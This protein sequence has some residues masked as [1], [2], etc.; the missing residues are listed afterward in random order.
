MFWGWET[1]LLPVGVLGAVLV[2][3]PRVVRWRWDFSAQ[4]M[5]RFW[6][7]CGV[8]FMA[9]V[10][11][12]FVATDI[13]KAAAEYFIWLPII[14]FPFLAATIYSARDNVRFSTYLWLLRPKK[15]TPATG[16]GIGH[17]V[18]YWYFL[19]CFISSSM[20][21]VRDEWFY[22]GVTVLGGWLLWSVRN[23][24]EP[25]WVW[26]AIL[27]VVAAIGLQGHL[28]LTRLKTLITVMA[29]QMLLE[30]SVTDLDIAQSRTAIGE[31]GEIKLSGRI[32]LRL[33][34]DAPYPPPELL[35]QASYNIYS[36]YDRHAVWSVQKTRFSNMFP[37][38]DST[39]WSLVSNDTAKSSVTLSMP[40]TAVACVMPVPAGMASLEGLVAGLVQTNDF[41]SIRVRDTPPLIRCKLKY[42]TT[43]TQEAPVREADLA[44]PREESVALAKI[45]AEL[46]LASQPAPEVLRR[47]GAFF[48]DN[49]HYS[50][51]LK[52]DTGKSP[53]RETPVSRFLLRN[54]AGHCEYFATAATLLLRQ[55]GVPA[56]Y[57][58]GYAVPEPDRR[59]DIRLVRSRHAHAWTLAYV[60]GKWQDFDTTPASWN[61]AEENERSKFEWLSDFTSWLQYRFARWRYYGERGVVARVVLWLTPVF[62]IWL[63]WRLFRRKHRV[64]VGG[65]DQASSQ[66]RWP[67]DDSEF[68]QIVQHLARTGQ[69]RR[70]GETMN[71]WLRR[72]ESAGQ[73]IGDGVSLRSILALHYAYRF[74]PQGISDEHRQQLKTSAQSWLSQQ[75]VRPA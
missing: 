44:I 29:G 75:N 23:R 10:A 32:V 55:A 16:K 43:S 35:R 11:Y 15:S 67:G 9:A 42:A 62:I 70:K 61:E 30:R 46:G 50:R 72:L 69:S 8:L 52:G 41:G 59:D 3:L 40:Q 20:M 73:S 27:L 57:A 65:H 12:S 7:L 34:P 26:L 5:N 2:E 19:L 36:F 25:A 28:A 6:D 17:C 74:D 48:R 63:L 21:N 47:V 49:F 54:R 13:A 56:R 18:P 31:V 22:A 1:G 33:E 53:G 14:F 24:T 51:Y 39:T 37:G 71:G 64:S 45:A 38:P 66:L 4:D 68:Y 58:V 60:N